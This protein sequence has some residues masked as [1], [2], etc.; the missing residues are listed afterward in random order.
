MRVKSYSVLM[1]VY[2][3]EKPG[4]LRD[5]IQ[6]IYDQTVPT[7][8]FVLICDGPLTKRLDEV[9]DEMQKKFGK[10]MRVIRLLKNH[11][12]GYCLRMGVNECKNDL[13]AR[14]DS[15]DISVKNR[16]EKELEV[17]ARNPNLSVVGGFVGEFEVTIDAVKSVRK[18]PETNEEIIEFGKWRNPMNHP[19]V[20]FRRNDIIAVGNYPDMKKCQDWYLWINL[21]INGYKCYNIQEILVYMREDNTTFERRSGW[22]YFKIQKQLI[23]NMYKTKYISTPQYLK[24][25]IVRFGSAMAP[26]RLRKAMFERFMRE[27]VELNDG[28]GVECKNS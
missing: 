16:C 17:F 1:S 4:I 2:K 22:Q 27:K 6:S 10:K 12:L 13:V 18:V 8:D 15:D 20:M 3:N 14:M 25:I 19:S 28:S 21:L 24:S 5:S 9:I 26:N 7:D 23:D 11:G